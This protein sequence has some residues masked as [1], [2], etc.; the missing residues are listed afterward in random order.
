VF[1]EHSE[2]E[3]EPAVKAK[4]LSDGGR[5]ALA[6][7]IDESV[8]E[9]FPMLPGRF[10]E[11]LLAGYITRFRDAVAL[12][13]GELRANLERERADLEKPFAACSRVLVSLSALDETA[14][15]VSDQL[16]KIAVLEDA[17]LDRAP[18]IDANAAETVPQ[19]SAAS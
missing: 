6:G 12:G 1:G 15:G 10:S 8:N 14:A 16:N 18:A 2:K 19:E 5:E 11:R 9:K 17:V 4:R 13:L 7:M 3:I